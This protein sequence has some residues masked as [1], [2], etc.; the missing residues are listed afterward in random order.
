MNV[1]IV[2][3][4][5][6]QRIRLLCLI[7]FTPPE[8]LRLDILPVPMIISFRFYDAKLNT[9]GYDAIS[10]AGMDKCGRSDL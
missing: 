3:K 10:C 6:A 8:F 1:S 5:K 7:V 4:V 9:G 2:N